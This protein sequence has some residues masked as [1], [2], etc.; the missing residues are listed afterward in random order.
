MPY[1]IF[2]AS[3]FIF[4]PNLL[5][6]QQTRTFA[7]VVGVSDYADP[8]NNLRYCDD[9]AYRF[10][11]QLRSPEGGGV[12]A[13][14]IAVLVDEAATKANILSTAR[15]VF[16]KAGAN[17]RLIFFFSGHGTTGAFIP[18]DF[19]GTREKALFH[20][21]IKA[22]FRESP[23]RY[24]I[25]FADACHSGSIGSGLLN[26]KPNSGGSEVV[27]MM[28]SKAEEVSIEQPRMRQ[29][30]FSYYLNRALIGRADLDNNKIIT[31]R[32][33]YN[34]VKANVENYTNKSQ[35]PVIM[36]SFSPHL[37]VGVLR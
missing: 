18:R 13:D 30:V 23:A 24:K 32:E 7:V 9:D 15:E 37:P 19:D 28:S 35:K 12:V 5:Q 33:V 11:A 8:K 1:F 20:D 22:I 10:Y 29:G 34:Y 27:I 4:L 2:F 26:L 21:E 16:G 3:L 36:G 25:I 6:A 17:D 31:I 14:H